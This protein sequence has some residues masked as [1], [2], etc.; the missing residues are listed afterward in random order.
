MRVRVHVRVCAGRH[1]TRSHDSPSAAGTRSLVPAGGLRSDLGARGPFPMDRLMGT[2]EVPPTAP[3]RP[4]TVRPLL[5][6]P[7][8]P[9]LATR[10]QPRRA[11]R[12]RRCRRT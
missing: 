2:R 12:W 6:P 5:P 9:R 11:R 7:P 8:P 3:A 4:D 10:R 1:V